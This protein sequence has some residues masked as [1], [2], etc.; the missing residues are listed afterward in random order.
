MEVKEVK[1]YSIDGRV[2]YKTPEEAIYYYKLDAMA[3]L[4]P[5]SRDWVHLVPNIMAN[6]QAIKKI[7]ES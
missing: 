5:D 7:M 6:Y 3:T 1:R 2:G 4:H